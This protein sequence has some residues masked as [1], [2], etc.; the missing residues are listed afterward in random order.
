MHDKAKYLTKNFVAASV[1]AIKQLDDFISQLTLLNDVDLMPGEYDPS[2]LMLPQQPLHQAMFVKSKKMLKQTF[3][4]TTNPYK[5]ELNGTCFLG[6]SGQAIDDIRRS[7]SIDD[8]IEIMKLTLDCGHICPTCPDTLAC[9]PFYGEDPFILDQLPNV[10]FAGNQD[11]FKQD[12]YIHKD[13]S[14]IKV[15]LLSLPKFSDR[16]SLV[17]FNLNTSKAEE[18]LF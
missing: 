12:V 17:L 4:M 9:Y 6:T 2:N 16:Q 1:S 13:N 15:N 5:F 8:P 10:Y 11:V 7:T 14:D 18:I 3:Q